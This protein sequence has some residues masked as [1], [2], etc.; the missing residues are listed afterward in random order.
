MP[1]RRNAIIDDMVDAV[2]TIE[3]GD[4]V[5]DAEGNDY[6][7]QETPRIVSK[8]FE[9]WTNVKSFPAVF[10]NSETADF[11]GYKQRRYRS[12]DLFVITCYVKNNSDIEDRLDE[13]VCDV[14]M[15]ISQDIKRGGIASGT[16]L[17]RAEFETRLIRPYGMA[18]LF[19]RVLYHFGV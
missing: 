9:L 13:V 18:E 2:K 6:T 16:I 11:D 10:V 17:S 7:Y 14:I 1:L 19:V 4:V 12:E 3:K 5:Q 15:A 8:D